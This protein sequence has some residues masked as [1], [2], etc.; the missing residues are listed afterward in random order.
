M[1]GVRVRP[2]QM[3]VPLPLAPVMVFVHA[4]LP[5]L[6]A[7]FP[8]NVVPVISRTDIDKLEKWIVS[9]AGQLGLK[10]L[11]F[12]GESPLTAISGKERDGA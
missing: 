10:D 2:G 1:S 6:V 7:S 9:L 4:E 12:S 8:Q 5:V 3:A 11:E